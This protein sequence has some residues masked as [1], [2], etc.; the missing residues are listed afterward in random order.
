MVT[1]NQVV[2]ILEAIEVLRQRT[3]RDIP[4]GTVEVVSF[5]HL[6]RRLTDA[7]LWRYQNVRDA[8]EIVRAIQY[9]DQLTQ[10]R[11]TSPERLREL[12]YDAIYVDE[13]Q[14]FLEEE[15]RLLK[16]LCRINENGGPN[17]YVFYDD[18]QNLYGRG[19][20]NWQ[21]LGLDV[22]GGRSFVMTQCFRNTRPVIEPA[23]NVL[24]DSFAQDKA[25]VPTKE[26]GD[27]GRWSRNSSSLRRGPLARAVRQPGR[28]S[29][30][31]PPSGFDPRGGAVAGE[32][33]AIYRHRAAGATG[34]R[35]GVDVRAQAGRASGKGSGGGKTALRRCVAHA[36]RPSRPATGDARADNDIHSRIRKGL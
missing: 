22:P 21:S 10:V 9:L 24:Y 11:E 34:R 7:G 6:M 1:G 8:Q 31:P 32:Q 15:F 23:F 13:G 30:P 18:A 26:L 28:R 33:G 36:V 25:K 35:A 16:G 20:P 5:N 12:A 4:A 17:L 27:L 29:P 14:D 3:G 2:R 19:R